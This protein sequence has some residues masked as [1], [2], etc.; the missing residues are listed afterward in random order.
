MISRYCK[1]EDASEDSVF[2]FGARQTGKTTLLKQLFPNVRYYDLLKSDEYERLSR[3]P[4]LFREE[5]QDCPEGE[6]IIVDEIQKLPGL[7]NEVHWLMTNCNLKFIL[8]GSSARKLRRGGFNLL[9]GRAL[10]NNLYPLVSSEL[11]DF[12]LDRAINNGMIP[13]HYLVENASKRISGYVGLYL[14]TEIVE[15]ALVRNL[16]SFNRFL[17]VAALTSGEMLV[18]TN[19]ANDCGV[20]SATVKSYFD[21]LIDTLFGYVVP[22]YTKVVKRKLIQAPKFYLFDV[23]VTNFLLHRNN[24]KQGSPEYGHA[25]EQF[26]VLEIWAYLGYHGL[27]NSISYWRTASGVE[28]D[29]VLGDAKVGLEIKSSTEVNSKHLKGL[30]SFGE[31]YPEARLIVVSLDKNRRRSD[32]IEIIPIREFLDD[33][34]NDRIYSNSYR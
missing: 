32:N 12:D 10:V 15:E 13:R 18:Y 30:K 26:V 27:E 7:L 16:S 4:H 25:F 2:F 20:S 21:I 8:T 23:G 1:L 19:V 22:A 3:R 5:L 14:K 24:L 11:E 31:D 6:L 29:V 17:E 28:I 9:G 33:L 34:W